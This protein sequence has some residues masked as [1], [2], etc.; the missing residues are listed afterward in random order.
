MN[1]YVDRVFLAGPGPRF[2][3]H[4]YDGV[5][6]YR[7]GGRHARNSGGG[8]MDGGSDVS[9]AATVVDVVTQM[10][11]AMSDTAAPSA[12]RRATSWPPPMSA[13]TRP[14]PVHPGG[15][16]RTCTGASTCMTVISSARR[17]AP[18][19]RVSSFRTRA[20]HRPM[21]VRD[22]SVMP[23]VTPPAGTSTVR[24][25]VADVMSVPDAMP[26]V[27]C[28]SR[29]A[30]APMGGASWSSA[31]GR[32]AATRPTVGAPVLSGSFCTPIVPG[33]ARSGLSRSPSSPS[34]IF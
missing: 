16:G 15:M 28:R 22:A 2:R 31:A 30:P 33:S 25:V 1:R 29:R 11:L 34:F 4:R 21:L 32:Y 12:P 10:D 7:E 27:R 26:R 8:P 19:H 13:T 6:L 17:S 23:D 14:D 9:D 24:D 18:G 5:R 20:L 3:P